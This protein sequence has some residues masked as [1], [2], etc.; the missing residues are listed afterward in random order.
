MPVH[1]SATN[2]YLIEIGGLTVRSTDE[3][4]LLK[5]RSP[6]GTESTGRAARFLVKGRRN[7]ELSLG[8]IR[9]RTGEVEVAVIDAVKFPELL[10][11]SPIGH[12][13]APRLVLAPVTA[14][15]RACDL[16]QARWLPEGDP[17]GFAIV[18]ATEDD[19]NDG[20]GVDVRDLLE[21]AG[22]VAFG[23][24]KELLGSRDAARRRLCAVFPNR[25]DIVPVVAFVVTRCLPLLNGVAAGR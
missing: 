18:D 1:S 8:H 12:D 24:R 19:L 9:W 17:A 21:Q 2:S 3:T 13:A 4:L 23:S 11:L 5:G 22:C 16:G 7:R 20:A 25:N 10:P 6:D 15:R 14:R